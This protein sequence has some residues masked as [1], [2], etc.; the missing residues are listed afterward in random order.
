[1]L[2]I[3]DQ[4]QCSLLRIDWRLKK[5]QRFCIIRYE[6]CHSNSIEF[7]ASV[8][9]ISTNALAHHLGSI[10]IRRGA[11]R[12]HRHTGKRPPTLAQTK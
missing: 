7:R 8:L 4:K 1:M 5:N 3:I 9:L 2:S 12:N 10:V 11:L 6:K